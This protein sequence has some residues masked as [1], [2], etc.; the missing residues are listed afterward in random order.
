MKVS[1]INHR[2]LANSL[3]ENGNSEQ[4]STEEQSCQYSVVV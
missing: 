2:I 4:T 3:T 1:I